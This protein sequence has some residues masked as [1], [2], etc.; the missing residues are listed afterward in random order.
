MIYTIEGRL[1]ENFFKGLAPNES[2]L[3]ELTRDVALFSQTLECE[4]GP[5]ADELKPTIE[6][7]LKQTQEALQPIVEVR[8]EDIEV[9]EGSIVILIIVGSLS[10]PHIAAGSLALVAADHLLG[11]ALHRFGEMLANKVAGMFRST[12]GTKEI[13]TVD[14]EAIADKEALRMANEHN[15]KHVSEMR[16]VRVGKHSYQYRYSCG[17]KRIIVTVD[18]QE[19]SPAQ[20]WM[21]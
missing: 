20:V 18:P 8:V 15:C 17:N 7:A 3:R 13:K 11:G 6:T 12:F 21:E 2:Y 16:N 5:S 10:A 1:S 14:P 9:Q 19:V 4:G